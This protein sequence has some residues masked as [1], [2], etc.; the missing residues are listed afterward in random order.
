VF[1][2]LEMEFGV[3]SYVGREV[4]VSIYRCVSKTR[5]W[6]KLFY[7]GPVEPPLGSVQ[8][9]T[10]QT[11]SQSVSQTADYIL[12]WSANLDTS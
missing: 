12:D 10:S 6:A 8:P 7:A 1:I 9:P 5:R 11:D 2:R 4:G 3:C